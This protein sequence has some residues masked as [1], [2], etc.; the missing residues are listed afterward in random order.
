MGDKYI[1]DIQDQFRREGY[2]LFERQSVK[3][4][5]LSNTGQVEP[6]FLTAVQ[7]LINKEDRTSGFILTES[8]LAFHTTHYETK[9]EFIPELLR[10]IKIVH[11]VVQL[12]H[13]SRLGLRYLDAIFPSQDEKVNQYL[14]S[15]LHGIEFKAEKEYTLTESV[16]QTE[17]APVLSTGKLVTRVLQL[18]SSLL[19]Y[20]PGLSPH[21]LV[22]K[23]RFEIKQPRQHAIIDTDHFVEGHLSIDFL[24]IEEQLRSLHAI[25]KKAFESTITNHA[26]H[27]WS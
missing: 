18:A 23:E 17:C 14:A 22:Q 2:T 20:P 19:G 7:W 8:S 10:G 12:D 26:R 5:Q 9:E 13:L 16:F 15:G 6:N 25:L 1:N 21:G 3:Q 24:K 4:L 11:N 27:I